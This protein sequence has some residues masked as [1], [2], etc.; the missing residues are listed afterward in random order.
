M[1]ESEQNVLYKK[2][3]VRKGKPIQI[4]LFEKKFILL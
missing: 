4:N 3:V 1:K 2:S